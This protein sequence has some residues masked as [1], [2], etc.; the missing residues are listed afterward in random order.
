MRD[1]SGRLRF[2]GQLAIR[3]LGSP[4]DAPAFLKHAVARQLVDGG[5]L[6]PFAFSA[7]ATRIESPR[8][9]FVSLPTEWTDAQLRV[10]AELTLDLAEAVLPA[11]FKLKDASAWNVVFDGTVPRFCDH[12]SFEAVQ[13]RQWWAFGQFCRHFTFPLAC[14]HWRGLPA[15]DAFVLYRDGLDTVQAR[16]LLGL[17]GRISHLA[18]LLLKPAAASAGGAAA[19]PPARPGDT[20]HRSLIDYARRSLVGPKAAAGASAWSGYV[21]ERSHY[22]AAA[23]QAKVEQ[24]RHWLGNARPGTVLDLGCNTGEF[25]RLAL[26]FAQRVISLDADHDCVQ[27]LFLAAR[28]DTRLHP[29]V[30]DLGDLRGGRG[31]AA[32]E[33][34]G[35]ADRLAGQADLA[36]MLALV[37]HLH[38]GEGIPMDEVAAFATRLTRRDLIVELIE[39]DDPM[40]RRLSEQRRRPL[41]G[42]SIEVQ[43]SAFAAHFETVHSHR[44]PD[45]GRHLT[46]MRV[47][48]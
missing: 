15:R 17:R 27:D 4:D 6:V 38:V 29:V 33:F 37:H 39:P 30:A 31:W 26:E 3:P 28:G 23:V 16:A 9:R 41:D 7:D 46:W 21:G 45:T 34:P 12:F 44:L 43:R 1:P 48:L 20:L 24:V 47:R 18:P 32:A 35:L 2:D 22:T 11:G 19:A 8:Y 5:S 42:F 10:A 40:V 13:T 25:S 14:S 36:L